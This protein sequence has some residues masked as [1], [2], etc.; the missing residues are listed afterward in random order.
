MLAP[1]PKDF[2][3]HFR[4]PD[5]FLAHVVDQ[6][7]VVALPEELFYR[8]YMQQRLRDAWPGG[9]TLW[10]ARLGKAFCAKRA[11]RCAGCPLR[12]LLP[13]RRPRAL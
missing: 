3:I 6:F 9:R 8:G 4:L 13:G 7:L 2:A 10:G 1:Y 12:P 5:R 11:P